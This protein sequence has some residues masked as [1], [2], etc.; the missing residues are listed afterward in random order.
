MNKLPYIIFLTV[1]FVPFLTSALGILPRSFSLI[2]ELVSGGI[3]ILAIIY[4]SV[5]KSFIVSPK[6]LILFFILCLHLIF[7]AIVN[8][9]DAGT[10]VSGLRW[11]LRY[12]P[13]FLLPFVFHF[14]EHEIKG[15]FKFLLTLAILQFPLVVIQKF[16]LG[17]HPDPIAGTLVIGSVMSIY[18]VSCIVILAALYFRNYIGVKSFLVLSLILFLPTTLNETKGSIILMFAALLVILFSV[19]LK[20]SHIVLIS[21]SMTGMLLIFI[22]VYNQ[23][24]DVAGEQ[25]LVNFF[26][27]TDRGVGF[28]LYSGDALEINPENALEP[29]SPIIGALPSLDIQNDRIRRLDAVVLPIRV[30]SEDPIK[31]L[32]GLGLGNASDSS[33]SILSGRYPFLARLSKAMPAL[34]QLMWEIGVV[35]I[36]IYIVFFYF[37]YRDARS[38]GKINSFSGA[39]AIGWAGIVVLIVLSLPYKNFMIFN[40][41]GALFWYFS[42]YVAAERIRMNEGS[43][44]YALNNYKQSK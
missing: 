25:G 29:T 23:L 16:V 38:L 44:G 1:F 3:F 10:V 42:G 17:W 24:F 31:L 12:M 22:F 36:I 28:Y 7:G 14:S 33:I 13:L 27:D 26:S 34:P 37:I 21:A 19:K 39:F 20:K 2:F 4:G 15:Q 18:L 9:V 32:M 6:Y 30:L 8:S 5:N 35:G 40:V 11:H 41:L 43:S